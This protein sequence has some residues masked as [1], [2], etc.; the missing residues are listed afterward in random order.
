[1]WVESVYGLYGSNGGCCDYGDNDNNY[2]VASPSGSD[3]GSDSRS[4]SGS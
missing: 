1:M 3:S 2:V 4:N